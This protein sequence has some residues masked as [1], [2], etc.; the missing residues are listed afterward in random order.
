M[1]TNKGERGPME[2]RWP[3]E[4]V[5]AFAKRHAITHGLLCLDP[6]NL[7]L[8]TI[9]PFSLFPSP[10][11]YSHLKFIWSI[12]TAYNRLYNRISLDDETLEKALKPVIPIDNF[13]ER[14]WKIHHTSTRRQPI[15]LDIY[16]NDY[17]L[18][19][20]VNKMRQVEFNTISSAF[21]GLTAIVADLHK[22]IL[23]H[24]ID[25]CCIREL[26]MDNQQEKS[27]SIDLILPNDALKKS[28]EAMIKAFELYNNVNASILFIIVPDERN[29]CDQNALIDA[30]QKLKPTIRVHL[31][32]FEQLTD[33]LLLDE[34]NFNIYLKSSRDEIAIVYYRAG[35]IPEHYINE[36]CWYV[37][38]QIE[39]SR[40]IKCPTV[41][42]QLAGCKIVQEYLTHENIIEKYI[43]DENIS[44]NIR[45]TFAPMFTFDNLE[46]RQK[47]I[48]LLR[49]NPHDFVLK[50]N[51]EGGGNNKYDDEILNLI[52]KQ[53][54]R[55]NYY[56]AM[57]KILPP[58]CTT[59]LIKPNGK[60]L[61]HVEC[62][63]EIGIYGTMVTNVDTN[64]EYINEAAGYLVRTKTTDTNEGGVATGYSV[65]DCL[66]VSENNNEL[67]RIFSEKS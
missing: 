29:I 21:A 6:N 44:K 39:Q 10:Y 33:E 5:V 26:T 32:T 1:S 16:R 22:A 14:L 63:N 51:R 66:D 31:K 30:V 41:R 13:I 60:H 11:S 59:C 3:I 50:P 27:S 56:I 4:D 7:D 67:S 45:S 9:V 12:Q 52:E 24:A 25:N 2:L 62:I 42:S 28:A 19:T 46:T 43:H 55:L 61:L 64:E 20:K 8:A 18:D 40:A 53:E 35:Y 65:L 36:K 48:N 15:Q 58:K 34:N 47:N 54:N 37:R 23:R 17:M 57:E 49:E 38:E